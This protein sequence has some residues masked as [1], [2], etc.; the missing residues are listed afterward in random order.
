[1]DCCDY[2]CIRKKLESGEM[3]LTSC[4][5]AKADNTADD[6]RKLPGLFPDFENSFRD[7]IRRLEKSS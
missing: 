7:S 4:Y 6:A 5:D 3:K 2:E 1:M